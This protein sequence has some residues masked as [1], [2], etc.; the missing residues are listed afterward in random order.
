M[1]LVFTTVAVIGG[2]RFSLA[3]A[4]LVEELFFGMVLGAFFAARAA[5]PKTAIQR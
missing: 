4:I 2:M 3:V 1:E 5:Q